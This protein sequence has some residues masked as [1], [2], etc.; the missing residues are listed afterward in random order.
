MNITRNEIPNLLKTKNPNVIEI[1][2]E[3]GG[4]TDIYSN[5]I[6]DNGGKIWLLDLWQ[7]DGNDFYFSKQI[8][9]SERAYEEIIR[10]YDNNKNF[11]IIKGSS[12][13]EYKKFKDEFFDWIYIDADHSYESVLK[14]IKNWLPKVKSGG[15]ISGHDYDVH[16]NQINGEHFGV[17][18][19]VKEIFGDDFILTSEQYYKSWIHFVK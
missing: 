11:T 14:D 19:A 6:I 9:Q 5:S 18:R 10:K 13:S 15:I 16:P 2:V 7:T 3:Y 8:G 12:F 4:Y 17:D 1:G